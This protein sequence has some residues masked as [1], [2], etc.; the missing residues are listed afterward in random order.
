MSGK[1]LQCCQALPFKLQ[2]FGPHLRVLFVLCGFSQPKEK[3]KA[4]GCTEKKKKKNSGILAP[5]FFPTWSNRRMRDRVKLVECRTGKLCWEIKLVIFVQCPALCWQDCRCW[6]SKKKKKKKK[7]I[8]LLS[9]EV[10]WFLYPL[11]RVPL[12]FP[13]HGYGTTAIFI[14][15]F[16]LLHGLFTWRVRCAELGLL[17]YGCTNT[18]RL[19]KR[20]ECWGQSTC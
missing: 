10:L 17:P 14:L 6:C 15:L 11:V 4:M 2:I 1:V 19:V 5:L 18:E 7:V 8:V 13:A 12:Y 16:S 3:R 9:A 20:E